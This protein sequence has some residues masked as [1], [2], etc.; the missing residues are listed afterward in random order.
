[1]NEA[2]IFAIYSFLKTRLLLLQNQ[3]WEAQQYL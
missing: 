3:N 1:L 2:V